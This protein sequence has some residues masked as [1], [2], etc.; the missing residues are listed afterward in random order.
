[1]ARDVP[2]HDFETRSARADIASAGPALLETS[3]PIDKTVAERRYRRHE[4]SSPLHPAGRSLLAIRDGWTLFEVAVGRPMWMTPTGSSPSRRLFMSKSMLA[5]VASALIALSTPSFAESGGGGGGSGGKG[6]DSSGYRGNTNVCRQMVRAHF[7]P[8]GVCPR[9]TQQARYAQ[10]S[11]CM[12]HN[13]G[14]RIKG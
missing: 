4:R 11:R 1:L 5:L 6:G 13:A 7:C 8:T 14:V 12:R 3:V 10:L 9:G 2:D